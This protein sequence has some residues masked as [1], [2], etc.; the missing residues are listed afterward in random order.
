MAESN[1]APVDIRAIV[2]RYIGNLTEMHNEI[3]EL[4]QRLRDTPDDMLRLD[5]PY[6]LEAELLATLEVVVH[7]DIDNAIRR[8][9]AVAAATPESLRLDWEQA[10]QPLPEPRPKIDSSRF[11]EEDRRAIY[12]DFLLNR[13]AQLPSNLSPDDFELQVLHLFGRW[14]VTYRKLWDE[15]DE[16]AGPASREL[17]IVG[18]GE[19]LEPVYTPV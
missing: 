15:H 10:R 16:A 1:L 14:M 17:L 2:E 7:D 13:F 4:R 8:L 5:K 19:G 9:E 18:S 12:E 3:V 11:S 6:D